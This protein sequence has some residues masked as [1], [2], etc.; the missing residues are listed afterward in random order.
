MWTAL[1]LKSDIYIQYSKF[2]NLCA[3]VCKSHESPVDDSP[4]VRHVEFGFSNFC[5]T[6]VLEK[7][8]LSKK[9]PRL[10]LNPTF[11]FYF[12]QLSLSQ[13]FWKCRKQMS[14][15]IMTSDMIS[16]FLSSCKP[17]HQFYMLCYHQGFGVRRFPLD[18]SR[19]TMKPGLKM[20]VKCWLLQC[21]EEVQR[22]TS[23]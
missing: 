23:K 13:L 11:N 12:P 2:S 5:S 14:F 6:S 18:E 15:F 20:T 16:S 3:K 17:F 19:D 22:E 4:G 7:E 10:H 1:D 9:T 21:A 8:S